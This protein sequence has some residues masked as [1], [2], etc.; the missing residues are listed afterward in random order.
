MSLKIVRN[1]KTGIWRVTGTINGRRYRESTRTTSREH[2]EAFRREKERDLQDRA[3]LS[4]ANTWADAMNIYVEKGGEKRYL[5]PLLDYFG[6]YRLKN[7]TPQIVSAFAQ[8]KYGDVQPATVKRVFY[9]PMNAVMRAGHRAQLCPLILFEAPKVK[10]KPVKYADDQWLRLFLEHS[11]PRIAMTIL[12][13]TLTGARVTEAVNVTVSEVDLSRGS[14][15]LRKTKNGKSRRVTL[16]P[17]LIEPLRHWIQ[18]EGL[19]GGMALLGYASRY[20]VNQ[21]IERVCDKIN[22]AAGA[23]RWNTFI[24]EADRKKKV[25]EI[26]APPRHRIPVQPPGRTSRLCRSPAGRGQEPQARARGRRLGGHP[27][28]VRVIRSS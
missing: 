22:V 9:T 16:P 2:A 13:M 23:I 7:I 6:P 5:Q 12:F 14:A 26:I 3:Y 21:A 11:W 24:D 20:G 18:E 15:I 17:L 19:D 4:D 10:R 28:G 8:D 27:G 25:R 1:K